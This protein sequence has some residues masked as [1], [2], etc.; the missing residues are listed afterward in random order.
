LFLKALNVGVDGNGKGKGQLIIETLGTFPNS[1]WE[2]TIIKD[3]VYI[4]LP[5]K[6]VCF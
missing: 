1:L 6:E 5:W 2:G 4:I 3:D